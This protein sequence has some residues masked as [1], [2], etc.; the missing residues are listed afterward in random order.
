MCLHVQVCDFLFCICKEVLNDM[1]NW[2][3]PVDLCGFALINSFRRRLAD[4]VAKAYC[5][6]ITPGIDSHDLILAIR[7]L[8]RRYRLDRK[9]LRPLQ[10]GC[11]GNDDNAGSRSLSPV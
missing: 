10:R 7:E 4:D 1:A 6:A 9:L 8:D 11:L 5:R 2:V 3:K